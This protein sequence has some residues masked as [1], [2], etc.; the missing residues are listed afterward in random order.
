MGVGTTKYKVSQNLTIKK[1]PNIKMDR[2]S[3]QTLH[4]RRY[5]DGK[6]TQEK[7]L[8]IMCHQELQIKITMRYNYTSIKKTKIKK[9]N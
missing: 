4:H 5:M 6:Q 1:N 9:K 3:E 8:N 7:E 2:T